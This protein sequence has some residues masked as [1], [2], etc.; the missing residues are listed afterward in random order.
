MQSKNILKTKFRV[1]MLTDKIALITGGTR[2]IGFSIAK[3]YARNGAT[4]IILS[5]NNQQL[6]RAVFDLKKIGNQVYSY[7]CDVSDVEQVDKLS[8][9][10]NQKFSRLDILVN[11]AAILGEIKSIEYYSSSLWK[12]VID[13]NLNGIFYLTQRV[14]PLIKMSDS[15]S[16]INVTSSVGRSGRKE[17]GA[18]AVSKFGVEGLTQILAQELTEYRIRVNAVNPGGTRSVMRAEVY[19]NEDPLSLPHPD[20]ITDIFLYLASDKSEQINGD[21]FNA[22]EFDSNLFCN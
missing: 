2:G 5:R 9:T 16:I 12:E 15:G 1:S 18:Y 22:R 14:I 21:S 13:I 19:P 3:K 4:V 10:L 8:E 11:N 6:K 20:E 17:W 7:Q